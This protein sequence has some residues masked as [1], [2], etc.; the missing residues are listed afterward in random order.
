MP[1]SR[2]VRKTG[3]RPENLGDPRWGMGSQQLESP[4]SLVGS[5]GEVCVGAP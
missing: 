5:H 4:L 2:W 1:R 3:V